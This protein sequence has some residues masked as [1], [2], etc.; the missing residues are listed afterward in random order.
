MIKK[1]AAQ[2]GSKKTGKPSVT[3]GGAKYQ[4]TADGG[5][6]T[7]VTGG[8]LPGQQRELTD[9]E[10]ETKKYYRYE[11][12]ELIDNV[13]D[14]EAMMKESM[15]YLEETESMM[16]GDDLAKIA[17]MIKLSK[18][19]MGHHMHGVD[20]VRDNVGIM[21]GDALDVMDEMAHVSTDNMKWVTKA[22]KKMVVLNKNHDTELESVKEDASEDP[23][24]QTGMSMGMQMG[25]I[26]MGG[27]KK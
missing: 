9:K 4:F 25:G 26:S 14:I 11:E 22:R 18:E 10:L 8:G 3:V 12:D 7:F 13:G 1:K 27:G 24:N 15:S 17:R 23:A 19:S 6:N 5:A 20:T 2:F 21:N 16:N